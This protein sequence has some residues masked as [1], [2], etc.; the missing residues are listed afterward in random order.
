[1]KL[2]ISVLLSLLALISG[3][4]DQTVEEEGEFDEEGDVGEDV[5]E[6]ARSINM[7]Y[8][9]VNNKNGAMFEISPTIFYSLIGIIVVLMVLNIT[10]LCYA[11]KD[12]CCKTKE[13]DTVDK[14]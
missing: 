12:S 6:Y 8:D 9:F 14:Y 13:V 2:V 4:Q 7:N 11:S 1:M 3:Y 10:C 5:E